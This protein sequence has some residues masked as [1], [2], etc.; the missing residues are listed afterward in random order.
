MTVPEGITIAPAHFLSAP[1]DE[2]REDIE[3]DHHSHHIV[4][5]DCKDGMFDVKI[6]GSF[7]TV[8]HRFSFE[9]KDLQNQSL[10]FLTTASLFGIL[11]GNNPDCNHGSL[12]QFLI[13]RKLRRCPHIDGAFV[14]NLLCKEITD[15]ES[16]LAEHLEGSG[17]REIHL[18]EHIWPINLTAGQNYKIK[19]EFGDFIQTLSFSYETLCRDNGKQVL[20]D[21][22]SN[23]KIINC[24]APQTQNIAFNIY[25]E[26]KDIP[27]K[28]KVIYI[29]PCKH[30]EECSEAKTQVNVNVDENSEKVINNI[31]VQTTSGNNNRVQGGNRH[32]APATYNMN[33]HP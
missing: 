7:T 15:D 29:E 3:G 22:R 14:L 13:S 31:T 25:Q 2:F 30:K 20:G 1:N 10:C 9:T 17:E 23:L 18:Q 8:Y 24:R 6:F 11:G 27:F 28:S 19:T 32:N 12:K 21:I 33:D 26:E 5:I 16:K 4:K